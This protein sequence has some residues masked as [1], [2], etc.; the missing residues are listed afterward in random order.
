MAWLACGTQVRSPPSIPLFNLA[1]CRDRIL[2]V[3]L[4]LL[5]TD[6]VAFEIKDGKHAVE[7][8]GLPDGSI[9][10]GVLACLLHLCLL[11][12]CRAMSRS[13]CVRM[14]ASVVAVLAQLAASSIPDARPNQIV[15]RW[16][17]AS[18]TNQITIYNDPDAKSP[19]RFPT[20]SLACFD[21]LDSLD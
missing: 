21:L 11:L 7:V 16:F 20:H 13:A 4:P 6:K 15:L 8:L 14:F 10:T 2:S 3:Y 9:V 19:A 1:E 18:T 5:C 17:A 12:P